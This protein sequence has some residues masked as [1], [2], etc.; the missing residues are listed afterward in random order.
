MIASAATAVIVYIVSYINFTLIYFPP[1]FY[2]NFILHNWDLFYSSDA[3]ING[4]FVGSS[5]LEDYLYIQRTK[6]YFSSRFKA[7]FTL[8][9]FTL[10][11]SLL[12]RMCLLVFFLFVTLAA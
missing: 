7:V 1:S 11:N 6:Q 3:Q 4:C 8:C 10:L 5:T 9:W 12:L 2:F